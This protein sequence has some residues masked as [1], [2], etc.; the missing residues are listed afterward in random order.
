MN[1]L[2]KVL[3]KVTGILSIIGGVMTI[4]ISFVATG[5]AQMLTLSMG[6]YDA[7][8][9][10]GAVILLIS[11]ILLLALGI[12]GIKYC[13]KPQKATL[14]LISGAIIAA[15]SVASMILTEELIGGI[16]GLALSVLF[17]IGAVMNKKSA[18]TPQASTA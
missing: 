6:I 5:S 15:L 16:I 18:S 12:L 4:I 13:A 14:L 2:G 3:L 9:T 17:I 8:L 1:T 10:I 11:G 7:E